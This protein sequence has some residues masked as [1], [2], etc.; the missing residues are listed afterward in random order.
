MKVMLDPAGPDHWKVIKLGKL[1]YGSRK[2]FN[3]YSNVLAWGHLTTLWCRV[4]ARWES[5][6][7]HVSSPANA[8]ELLPD[9]G[10]L[11]GT[12]RMTSANRR[13]IGRRLLSEAAGWPGDERK[14]VEALLKLNLAHEQEDGTYVVHDWLEHQG[15][16]IAQ[17]EYE[18]VRKKNQRNRDKKS[19][20]D[21]PADVP[22]D[23]GTVPPVPSLPLP[24]HSLSLPKGESESSVPRDILP[25][26]PASA[27]PQNGAADAGTPY[28]LL[29][30]DDPKVRDLRIGLIVKQLQEHNAI[31]TDSQFKQ[32]A[33]SWYDA[34][35][36]DETQRRLKKL[37]PKKLDVFRINREHFEGGKRK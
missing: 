29:Q 16:I 24:I 15:D 10:H 32:C 13:A 8:G 33:T 21:V 7:I 4:M 3:P 14:F 5:G 19:P 26:P 36:F 35:G 37:D 30:P 2:G 31:G 18:R 11:P 25:D 9:A 1:L 27:P 34:Y 6:T 17:R 20:K 23:I 12:G 22:R 28:H